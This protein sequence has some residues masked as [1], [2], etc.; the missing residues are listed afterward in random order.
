MNSRR[1]WQKASKS[2]LD[3]RTT[4]LG[5][6]SI[7]SSG[8]FWLLRLFDFLGFDVGATSFL[9]VELGT[10]EVQSG[11]D[12]F[13]PVWEDNKCVSIGSDVDAVGGGFS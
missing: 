1:V 5:N 9:D 11:L 4:C 6:G 10:E 2:S 8:L 12:A 3:I 7:S 13:F